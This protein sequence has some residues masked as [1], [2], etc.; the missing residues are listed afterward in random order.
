MIF[1]NNTS[2]I[3]YN[4]NQNNFPTVM[5]KRTNFTNFNRISFSELNTLI[6][7]I[8]ILWNSWSRIFHYYAYKYFFY[9]FYL[10][11][12]SWLVN[13]LLLIYLCFNLIWGYYNSHRNN[14]LPSSSLITGASPWNETN[15][16]NLIFIKKLI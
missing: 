12:S 6:R 8:C 16:E 9:V 13:Y 2:N 1:S 15:F 10:N 4:K 7:R 11:V 14:F 3:Y 5:N